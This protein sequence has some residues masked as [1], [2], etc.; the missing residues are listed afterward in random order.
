M[1]TLSFIKLGLG[2]L[3]TGNGARRRCRPEHR[4]QRTVKSDDYSIDL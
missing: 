2:K 3:A 1:A 4:A